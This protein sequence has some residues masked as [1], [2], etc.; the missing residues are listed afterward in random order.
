M[1]RRLI[2]SL[3]RVNDG[4]KTTIR[5]DADVNSLAGTSS[6]SMAKRVPI[7][8]V[9]LSSFERLRLLSSSG[10]SCVSSLGGVTLST[11]NTNINNITKTGNKTVVNDFFNPVKATVNN[12]V[13]TMVKTVKKEVTAG[14]TG[15]V[16]LSGTVGTCRAKCCRVG[17]RARTGDGSALI[18]V[19]AFTRGGHRRFGR[20]RVLRSVPIS[21]YS[22]ITRRVTFVLC[23][24]VMGR[25]IR[26]GGNVTRVG[27][28]V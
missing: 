23:R 22:S 11:I 10:A 8:A 12:N 2:G 18:S 21:S 19:R 1:A 24:F 25:I 16:P 7:M 3:S 27:G 14:G 4:V 26:V 15:E 9:T 6:V 20:S 28:S 13:N 5:A 17:G